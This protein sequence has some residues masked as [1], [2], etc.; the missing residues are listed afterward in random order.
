LGKRIWT[1]CKQTNRK[2]HM[3]QTHSLFQSTFATVFRYADIQTL[4][5]KPYSA[6][7]G[8]CLSFFKMNQK[9]YIVS[10]YVQER[11][12]KECPSLQTASETFSPAAN[13]AAK[14]E[15]VMEEL[16]KVVY[17]SNLLFILLL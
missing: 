16:S 9:V 13:I 8:T 2:K 12:E 5:N 4:V 15:N 14:S 11:H 6:L 7:P 17:R 1:L 10:M 3:H